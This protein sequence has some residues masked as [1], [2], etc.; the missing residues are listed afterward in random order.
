LC[1]FYF[2]SVIQAREESSTISTDE[3]TQQLA[4]SSTERGRGNDD[5]TEHGVEAEG[6]GSDDII[7]QGVEEGGDVDDNVIKQ[8]V[9]ERC[10]DDVTVP[11]QEGVASSESIDTGAGSIMLAESN[12]SIDMSCVAR[13][14]SSDK[15]GSPV[16]PTTALEEVAIETGEPQQLRENSSS[17]LLI[18]NKSP[19]KEAEPAPDETPPTFV[20]DDL[21]RVEEELE[22][23]H[24]TP[25]ISDSVPDVTIDL[26]EGVEQG[27]EPVFTEE[28]DIAREGEALTS[29][30]LEQ[31]V[32]S[33]ST[34]NLVLTVINNVLRSYNT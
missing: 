18:T 20:A 7:E 17:L 3:L 25:S 32:S 2:S 10:N 4:E 14:T 24:L 15:L 16:L 30:S 6:Q 11:L 28:D 34:K 1:K 5:V 9:E 13:A 19:E 8:G 33:G 23:V 29:I 27:V 31:Q 21:E 12:L 26:E 22:G